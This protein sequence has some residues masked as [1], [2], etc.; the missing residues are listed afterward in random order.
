VKPDEAT[1]KILETK[2]IR[3]APHVN[4]TLI[5]NA[6]RSPVHAM[7]DDKVTSRLPGDGLLSA[8]G[9][10]ERV[11]GQAP[12]S[13]DPAH[14]NDENMKRTLLP[15]PV[16]DWGENET[17]GLGS[18]GTFI[19]AENE[20]GV[21]LKQFESHPTST[22]SSLLSQ[23]ETRYDASP[24]DETTQDPQ[25]VRRQL[26]PAPFDT[27]THSVLPSASTSSSSPPPTRPLSPGAYR[28]RPGRMSQRA[29]S[30]D[31]TANV[32]TNNN[33][34]TA[35]DS[36]TP[37]VE[38]S[39][40]VDEELVPHPVPQSPLV[41]ATPIRRRR[42][43]A[44]ITIAILV[45]VAIIVGVTTGLLLNPR[46]ST[47]TPAPTIPPT[48]EPGGLFLQSLPPY[49]K[50]SLLNEKSPQSRAFNWVTT[51]DT[52]PWR[53]EGNDTSKRLSRM[54]QRFVLATLY[55]S[56]DGE[57]S[58]L[59]RQ[60]W[61]NRTGSECDWRG[62]CCGPRCKQ[63]EFDAS[64]DDYF[65][66]ES[67]STSLTGLFLSDNNLLG[68][69]P[70]EMW[71]LRNLQRLD[72][73]RNNLQA[74]IPSQVAD[75]RGLVTLRLAD[76]VITSGIPTQLGLM[77]NLV[78]LT[79]GSPDPES[80]MPG[81]I[82]TELA[83]LTA[84]AGLQLY[85]VNLN[86]SLPSELWT[87]TLLE[88]LHLHANKLTSSLPSDLGNLT[89]LQSLKLDRNALTGPIPVEWGNLAALTALDLLS[90]RVTSTIP[91]ELGRLTRLSYI[92]MSANAIHGS[93]PKEMFK[94]TALTTFDL[95]D[96]N[97]TSTLPTEFGYLTNLYEIWLRG[98][99]LSGPIATEIG[100]LSSL[101]L[102]TLAFNGLNQTIPTQLGLL[103]SLD[104]LSL[105]SNNLTG[106]V[107][108]DLGKTAV[109]FLS[110]SSNRLNSTL[111]AAL[112]LL[113][114]LNEFRINRNELSGSI[115]S[116]FAL[117]TNLGMPIRLGTNRLTGSVPDEFCQLVEANSLLIYADC[118]EIVCNCNCRC[119][120]AATDDAYARS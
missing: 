35:R 119:T 6:C 62:C 17:A 74:S 19:R 94:L 40:V 38:A 98:N 67:D 109:S 59:E 116:E 99:Q 43:I 53:D 96:N 47:P 44:A 75:L 102:L 115:P 5:S 70:R 15:A 13:D 33:D 48:S 66:N 120:D 73:N 63:F 69:L 29:A 42:Q 2:R 78:D 26:D 113:S 85:G 41:E 101:T 112:G 117:M 90:N 110:L 37:M 31:S 51:N 56:T 89:N 106:S 72:L 45:L 107:P 54:L 18:D 49:T 65:G 84:L 55:F 114:N 95:M 108:S 76:A 23:N 61:L 27:G 86:S 10:R 97:I 103:T 71:L 105:E 9:E 52:V 22:E 88:W 118:E 104:F 83:S 87:L 100:L 14:T 64:P 92:S 111:P 57:T 77:T 50:A 25:N 68:T 39:L 30:S 21:N 46:P 28:V 79:I 20:S 58:W 16:K 4:R 36:E 1:L 12:E 60:N 7:S 8:E 32:A 93:I 81:T 82:P 11:V 3:K 24:G 91:T 34:E 80:A